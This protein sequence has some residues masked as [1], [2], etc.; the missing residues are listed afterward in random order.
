LILKYRPIN[1][2]LMKVKSLKPF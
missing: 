1:V 2:T